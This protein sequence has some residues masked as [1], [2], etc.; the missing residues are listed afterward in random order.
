MHTHKEMKARPILFSAPMVLAILE[1]RKN[2]TRRVVKYNAAIGGIHPAVAGI[3]HR[4]DGWFGF[5]ADEGIKRQFATTFPFHTIRCPYG[6]AGDQLWVKETWLDLSNDPDLATIEYRA[7]YDASTMPDWKWKP[8]IFMPKDYSRITLE[9]T[10]VRVERLQDISPQDA[11]KEGIGMTMR[12]E[13]P[14]VQR[15]AELWESINGPGS[16]AEN[17]WVWVVEFRRINP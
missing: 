12:N 7:D 5:E 13:P 9:V 10:E 14:A 11:I 3:V 1:A 6:Q 16:W 8:S 4:G 17:P 15:Y 2:Q